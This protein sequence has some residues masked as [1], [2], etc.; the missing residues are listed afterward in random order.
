MNLYF[1]TAV[2]LIS[3]LILTFAI[4]RMMRVFFEKRRTP[5]WVMVFSYIFCFISSSLAF[6]LFNI[7]MVNLVV[8]V[9]AYLIISLNYESSMIK[10]LIA[11]VCSYLFIIIIDLLIFVFMG[12]N[13]SLIFEHTGF[14]NIWGIVILSISAFLIALILSRFK[15]IKKNTISL[16]GFWVSAFV[17]PISSLMMILLILQYLPQIIMIFAVVI[18]F[19][20]NL[21]TLYLHNTLSAAYEDK[22]N[23]MLHAQEKEYYFNQCQL[24]Q[25]SAD[26][27]SSFKHDI[28]SHL[29]TIKDYA[30]K[31]SVDNITEYLDGLLG[32]IIKTE[33]YS[34]TGNTAFDSV[35]NCK[36]RNAKVDNVRLDINI[37]VPPVLNVEI[38]DVVTIMS[39]LLDNALDAVAKVED[40]FLKL[41][42]KFSKDGLFIKTENSFNGEVKYINGEAG[43]EKQIVTLKNGD[44]HGHG[45][46]NIRKAIEKYDGYIKTSHMGDTFSVVVFL[47]VDDG[48]AQTI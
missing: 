26:S 42:I 23:S 16:R 38:V 45:L 7:P 29:S 20:I 47:Y 25:E 19:S 2:Y 21:L 46:R 28:T 13:Y 1:Y 22:L 34:N 30:I 39:N 11:V 10:R 27:M 9:F 8:S 36:L 24:M 15:S 35:I 12:I 4:E 32:D 43:E 31:N 44:K 14:S 33:S 37:F 41:N 48:E 40:K 6:L 18:I 3:N 17:I 5:F